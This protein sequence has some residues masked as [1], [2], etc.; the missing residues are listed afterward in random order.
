MAS[1]ATT[2]RRLVA[3]A[4]RSAAANGLGRRALPTPQTLQTK[5]TRRRALLLP[6]LKRRWRRTFMTHMLLSAV[7]RRRGRRC[8]QLRCGRFGAA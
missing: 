5:S 1:I 6:L 3:R 7:E 2:R 8:R 4:N